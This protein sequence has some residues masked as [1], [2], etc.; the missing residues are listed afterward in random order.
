MATPSYELAV[1]TV[2]AADVEILKAVHTATGP[3]KDALDAAVASIKLVVDKYPTVPG[4][5]ISAARTTAES[6]AGQLASFAN[7][8]DYIVKDAADKLAAYPPSE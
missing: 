2:A 3:I 6:H 5:P 8:L 7:T 4:T 1:K